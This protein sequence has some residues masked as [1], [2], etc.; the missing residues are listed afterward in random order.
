[1]AGGIMRYVKVANAEADRARDRA[2][3]LLMRHGMT[4]ATFD[5]DAAFALFL[6]QREGAGLLCKSLI[7]NQRYIFDSLNEI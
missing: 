3:V 1:M 5:F 6:G 2:V 7:R 4:K